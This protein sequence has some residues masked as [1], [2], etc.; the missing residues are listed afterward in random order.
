MLQCNILENCCWWERLKTPT[1]CALQPLS[2]TG[3]VGSVRILK[4][5][6]KQQ[7]QES[8]HRDNFISW[9]LLRVLSHVRTK[10]TIYHFDMNPSLAQ[11]S[12]Q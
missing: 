8:L 2:H 11:K 6:V 12:V 7:T 4:F 10:I 5:F 9:G 3:A 1:V